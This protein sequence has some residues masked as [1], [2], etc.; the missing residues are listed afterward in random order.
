MIAC[1][2]AFDG[3]NGP[4]IVYSLDNIEE[5]W[6]LAGREMQISDMDRIRDETKV[7]LKEQSG[8]YAKPFV[9]NFPGILNI[10]KKRE[11]YE[12]QLSG[13][14]LPSASSVLQSSVSDQMK[15]GVFQSVLTHIEPRFVTTDLCAVDDH[16]LFIAESQNHEVLLVNCHGAMLTKVDLGNLAV[17]FIQCILP[18]RYLVTICTPRPIKSLGNQIMIIWRFRIN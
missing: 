8:K 12:F 14:C 7:K 10:E 9:Q 5:V 18:S 1:V 15:T 16:N 6:R 4:V 17:E 3:I 2:T 11:M 13:V